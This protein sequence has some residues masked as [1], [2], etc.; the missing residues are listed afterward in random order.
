MSTRDTGREQA[1]RAEQATFG[2]H[3]YEK[4]CVID[5]LTQKDF[6]ALHNMVVEFCRS[7]FP[8]LS[9]RRDPEVVFSDARVSYCFGSKIIYSTKG[10]RAHAAMHEV[11]HWATPAD[12]GHGPLWRKLYATIIEEF[13]GK[14]YSDKFLAE[15]ELQPVRKSSGK[16]RKTWVILYR[17]NDLTRWAVA[18]KEDARWATARYRSSLVYGDQVLFSNPNPGGKSYWFWRVEKS[19]AIKL[20]SG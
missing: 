15:C 19:K 9:Y 2:G 5:Y 14:S 4:T 20:T 12:P 8:G 18:P 7:K 6:L 3:W 11:A 17:E 1:Y 10:L 13:I 16:P